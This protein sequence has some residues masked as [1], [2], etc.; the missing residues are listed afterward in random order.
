MAEGTLIASNTLT[1]RVLT[2]AHAGE[3][4]CEAINSVGGGRSPPILVRM[5]CKYLRPRDCRR[6]RCC[7]YYYYYYLWIPDAPRCRGGYERREVTAGRYETVSLRCEVDSVP[8]DGVRFSWTYNGT[9]GDVLPMP[10]SKARN[11][12]LVSVLEYTPTVDT[13]FGTLACWA[14]NSVGR[15]RAPCIFNIVAGSTCP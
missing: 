7:C 15:Q 9:L 2:L 11:N 12:G 14:S 13:D 4:S 1:L 8:K 3:Y 5:K 6:R 10:N